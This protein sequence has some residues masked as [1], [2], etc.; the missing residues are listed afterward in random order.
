MLH[1]FALYIKMFE[2]EL[3]ADIEKYLYTDDILLL[4]GSRQVGKTSIMK[5][6]QEKEKRPTFFFDLEHPT[7]FKIFNQN[8]DYFV[9]YLKFQ[10]DWKWENIVVFVDEVQYLENPT[11]FLKYLHDHFPSIKLIVSGSSTLE[12]RGKMKDSLAWRLL[13][14]EVYPLNFK[15]FLIFKWKDIL[16]KRVR[17]LIPFEETNDELKMLY[18]EYNTFWWYPKVV[19]TNDEDMKKASLGQIVETYIQKDIKDI[20]KIRDV[21]KFNTTLKILADQSWSLLN[22]SEL[23]SDAIW[24]NRETLKSWLFL[25]ENT[26]II[27][28]ITPFSNNLR[29]ELIKM[30]K[31]FFC[32]NGIRNYLLN[33][34]E[35]D[36]S[37]FE[38][39]FFGDMAHSYRFKKIQFYRTQDKKEIDF[40]LNETPYELKLNYNGKKLIAL[41]FFKEKYKKDWNVI[42]LTKKEKSK[43]PIL[44]P[45]EI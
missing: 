12:I 32:D 39:T 31:I 18:Q 21:E 26:F 42:S 4:Y 45:W 33:R 17:N 1:L 8:P 3:L 7:H 24:I 34:Y 43:Y 27:W 44:Y 29:S 38:T 28:T 19:L 16:A 37:G 14:F 25:L 20:G 30:P 9:E 11:S 2:R 22:I 36:W 10:K 41:D 23:A 13:K 6:L 40:I 15:E 5:M 35:M